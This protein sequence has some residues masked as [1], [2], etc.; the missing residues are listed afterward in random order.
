MALTNCARCGHLVSTKAPKCPGCGM[1][2]PNNPITVEKNPGVADARPTPP[3][4]AN[5]RSASPRPYAAPVKSASLESSG[6]A[7]GWRVGI[8][9]SRLSIDLSNWKLLLSLGVLIVLAWWWLIYLPGTPSYAIWSLNR[10]LSNQKGAAAAQF[11]DFK[12][13][14]RNA[15]MRDMD[16]KT[17]AAKSPE[18]KRRLLLRE[19]IGG[20]LLELF[21]QPLARIA[22][23]R[24]EK[25][26]DTSHDNAL[27]I[28]DLLDALV[29]LHWTEA[30]TAVT[31]IYDTHGKAVD[32]TLTRENERGNW[33]ITDLSGPA[34]RDE[35]RKLSK[36]RPALPV[37]SPSPSGPDQSH[38]E[39]SV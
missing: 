34:V 20:G 9:G 27:G 7:G 31:R 5:A 11:I 13:V 23:D 37:P 38:R 16:E 32:V 17:A 28:I 25:I 2:P 6:R 36:E 1:P 29:N 21:A 35:F 14:T 22:R 26:V 8:E 15:V 12:K 39:P 30:N 33:R 3:G 24:F 10:D 19:T 18:E 4:D